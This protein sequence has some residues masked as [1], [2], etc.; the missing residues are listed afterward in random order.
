MKNKHIIDELKKHP[1]D[2]DVSLILNI[3]KNCLVETCYHHGQW[4]EYTF[5]CTTYT[6]WR[7]STLE[8][9]Y[10][11]LSDLIKILKKKDLV[12]LSSVDFPNASIQDSSDGSVDVDDVDWPEEVPTDEEIEDLNKTDLYWDSE[13]TDSEC[14]FPIGSIWSLEIN[15]N[16]DKITLED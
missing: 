6:N 3:N 11:D 16:G 7:R 5:T 10:I 15:I 8:V 1:K 14:E 4:K 12:E 2:S 9:D 13:I